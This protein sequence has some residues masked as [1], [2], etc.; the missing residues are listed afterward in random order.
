MGTC[1]ATV[2]VTA[3]DECGHFATTTY[4]TRIDNTNP[5]VA[6]AEAA[7]IAATTASDNC[8][9]SPVKTASTVGACSATVRVTATDECGSFAAA[10]SST[11]IDNTNPT[12]TAG[13]IAACYPTV[14]AAEAAAIAATTA[15]DNCTGSPVMSA[16]T[17]GR[18]DEHASV[19]QTHA[20]LLFRLTL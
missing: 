9:G 1:S 14:A 15:S 4:S 3:T 8:T 6:A 11:R 19:A 16:S 10:C 7:A 17:V 5:T 20:H 2:T 12:V 13:S 18:S